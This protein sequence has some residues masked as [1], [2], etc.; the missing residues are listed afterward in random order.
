VYASRQKRLHEKV[1]GLAMRLGALELTNK[2]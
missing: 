1:E 2:K